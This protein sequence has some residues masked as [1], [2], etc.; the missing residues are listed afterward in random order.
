MFAARTFFGQGGSPTNF[1]G[2]IDKTL[3]GAAACFVTVNFNA[4]G[5]ITTSSSIGSTGSDDVDGDTWFAPPASGVGAQYWLNA[6][7]ASGSTPTSGTMGAWTQLSSAQSYNYNSGTGG[8]V[9]SRAGTI[10]F[11]VASDS[12]GT[13]V[14]C[15]GSI[16]FSATRET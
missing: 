8:A 5:S 7:L 4:D 9:S 13:N 3:I 12:G 11:K 16:Y 15:S 1:G 14:V 6:V 10:D 2:S